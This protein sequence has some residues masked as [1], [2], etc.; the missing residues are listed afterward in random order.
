SKN[1]PVDDIVYTAEDPQKADRIAAARR[2]E[3]V[4]QVHART[5]LMPETK[6]ASVSDVAPRGSITST[7]ENFPRRL[8][9]RSSAAASSRRVVTRSPTPPIEPAMSAKCQSSR[10][11]KRDSG[12][13]TRSISQL[14][15]LNSTTIG[16]SP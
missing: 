8:T 11:L 9:A 4:C 10:S 3:N 7:S 2:T 14:L 12:W 6:R 5:D 1:S 13:N 15:L 16:S